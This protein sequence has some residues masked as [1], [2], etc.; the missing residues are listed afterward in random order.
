MECELPDRRDQGRLLDDGARWV[1]RLRPR[2]PIGLS[3]YGFGA[4]ITQ[5]TDGPR[6]IQPIGRFAVQQE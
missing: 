2:Q 1:R 4:Q 3:E 6:A 5:N